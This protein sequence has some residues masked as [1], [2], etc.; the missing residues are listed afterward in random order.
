LCFFGG[1]IGGVVY[2]SGNLAAGAICLT[3]GVCSAI[4]IAALSKKT[5]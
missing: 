4:I 1:I 5:K 2:E 3:I